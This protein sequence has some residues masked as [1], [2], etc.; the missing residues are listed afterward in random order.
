MDPNHGEGRPEAGLL[1]SEPERLRAIQEQHA[2]RLRNS[3]LAGLAAEIAAESE[4]DL[5]VTDDARFVLIEDLTPDGD[6]DVYL[7][8]RMTALLA[9][10][11]DA[12]PIVT[13]DVRIALLESD[14]PLP[15]FPFGSE[16]AALLYEMR[17]ELLSAHISGQ[18]PNLSPDYT[19]L[20]Y[21]SI[22]DV[23]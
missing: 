20:A 1:H 11:I 21:D 16:D 2:T 17:A 18:L 19:Q 15:V 12:D 3:G 8:L 7:G 23:P 13:V 14:L 4:R 5:M 10:E 9:S 22:V 6:T